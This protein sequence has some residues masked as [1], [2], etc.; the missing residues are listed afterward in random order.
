M[1]ARSE[2]LP[3]RSTTR[4][5]SDAIVKF[6]PENIREYSKAVLPL[7]INFIL[8]PQARRLS[9]LLAPIS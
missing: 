5:I 3:V 7:R 1:D 6:M 2:P 9:H 8:R 4:S